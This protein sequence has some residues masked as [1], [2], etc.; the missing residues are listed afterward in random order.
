[1][2]FF[3][4]AIQAY[5]HRDTVWNDSGMQETA[6]VRWREGGINNLN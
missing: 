2:Y 4:K 1:M 6:A 5:T 3:A